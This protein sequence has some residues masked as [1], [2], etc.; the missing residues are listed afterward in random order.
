MRYNEENVLSRIIASEG[1]STIAAPGMLLMGGM[2]RAAGRLQS[3]LASPTLRG[4]VDRNAVHSRVATITPY[5]NGYYT[6]P[7]RSSG[8]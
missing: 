1:Q 4:R 2:M 3:A 5:H 6:A 7:S 8:P